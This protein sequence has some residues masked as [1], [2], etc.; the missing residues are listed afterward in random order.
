MPI[1]ENW[2]KS[3]LSVSILISVVVVIIV[4]FVLRGVDF[5]ESNDGLIKVSARV[6]IYSFFVVSIIEF[7]QNH[8]LLE[9]VIKS[10][11]NKQVNEI[12][13]GSGPSTAPSVPVSVGE[14]TMYGDGQPT[15]GQ[16]SINFL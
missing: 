10:E 2:S 14:P 16:N 7:V 13:K 11:Q 15:E 8:Y 3:P 12:F 6:G 4:L 9:D 5:S 1:I